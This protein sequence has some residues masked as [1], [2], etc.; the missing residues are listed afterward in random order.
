MDC[1][2]SLQPGEEC[3]VR[4]L[5]P[6]RFN[7]SL[8][9]CPDLNT[10]ANRTPDWEEPDC[11]LLCPP[12]DPPANYTLEQGVL[13][14]VAD[15]V[16]QPMA[17][18]RVNQTN[19]QPYWHYAGCHLLTPCAVPAIDAC[20]M[21]IGNCTDVGAGEW[22]EMRCRD[23]LIGGEFM[24]SCPSG[25][26]DGATP[27]AFD[28]PPSCHCPVAAP[29]L[30]YR[31][32]HSHGHG[33][34]HSNVD[35]GRWQCAE[36]WTGTA[37][38]TCAIDDGCNIQV[39]LSGCVPIHSCAPPL[40]M[41]L[42]HPDD[43]RRV[44]AGSTCAARCAP[45][46]CV[47]GGPLSFACRSLR[48]SGAH[49]SCLQLQ[50]FA[51]L[52]PEHKVQQQTVTPHFQLSSWKGRAVSD[53]RFAGP[54]LFSTQTL[55]PDTSP[56]CSALGK[57]MQTGKCQWRVSSDTGSSLQMSAACKLD[58]PWATFHEASGSMHAVRQQPTRWEC[59]MQ[60]FRKLQHNCSSQLTRVMVKCLTARR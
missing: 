25:N 11:E 1:R 2:E 36:D 53:A 22:C 6:F 45:F 37:E 34:L 46:A 12:M 15:A 58:L 48:A 30:G 47:S 21:D 7:S 55:A 9:R 4:C 24:G 16:G 29:Q 27:L 20:R 49:V 28:R 18:C 35:G 60:R 52:H 31:P 40:P 13:M 3:E 51:P 41:Y 42:S 44:P 32:N 50:R 14:C 59:L 57:R 56:A 10:E 5:P 17:E 26:V 8:A 33:H 19:C 23:G 38:A 54:R 39:T 43:C